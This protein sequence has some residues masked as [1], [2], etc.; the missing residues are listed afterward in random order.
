M[1]G[2]ITM[3]NIYTR[4]INGIKI[5]LGKFSANE[6]NI[7]V[8]CKLYAIVDALDEANR[9]YQAITADTLK[10]LGY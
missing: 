6:Y 4:Y 5:R 8:G 1:K 7:Y 9:M 10:Y 3:A 2:V